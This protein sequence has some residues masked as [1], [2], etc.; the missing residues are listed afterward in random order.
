M[1]FSY[2]IT[3]ISFSEIFPMEIISRISFIFIIG[4]LFTKDLFVI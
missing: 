1:S 2:L 4:N 3:N